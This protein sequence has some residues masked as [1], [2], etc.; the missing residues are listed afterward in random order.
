MTNLVVRKSAWR[1]WMT[2]VLSIPLIVL[3]VDVLT[4]RRLTNALRDVLFRPDDTQLFEFRDI[5]W[6]WVMLAVAGGLALWSLRE[7]IVPSKMIE[8]DAAGLRLQVTAPFRPPLF[9]AWADIDDI[10]SATVDDDG[11][12]LPVLWV[13]FAESGIGPQSP[14]SARW[15]DDHTLAVLGTDWEKDPIEVARMLTDVAVVVAR[16]ADAM[17][18]FD[19]RA[20]PG[21]EQPIRDTELG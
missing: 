5:V 6:A 21:T 17:D 18:S 4:Q 8:A 7:L 10:G 9:V 19:D 20:E 1:M 14:W 2:S 12:L 13:K 15:M 3:A 11:D 16:D